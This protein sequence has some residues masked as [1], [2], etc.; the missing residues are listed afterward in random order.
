VKAA[1]VLLF[2]YAASALSCG[3]STPPPSAPS[4]SHTAK[5]A[6]DD[7]NRPLDEN[8]CQSLGQRLSEACQGRPNERSARVDGWCSDLVRG[9]DGG[10][11]MHDCLKHIRYMDSACL[12]SASNVHAMMECDSAVDRSP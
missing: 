10:S 8:E 12:R 4:P 7:P 9:V 2:A 6:A 11:W 5:P 3:G 1:T